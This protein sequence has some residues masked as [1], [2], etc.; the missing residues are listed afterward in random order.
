MTNQPRGDAHPGFAPLARVRYTG[1]RGRPP[2]QQT[3][4][5]IG[6]RDAR[7]EMMHGDGGAV[8]SVLRMWIETLDAC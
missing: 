8:G 6:H 3:G 4:T 7:G 5:V 1:T 2:G